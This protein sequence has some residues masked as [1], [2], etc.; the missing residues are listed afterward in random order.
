MS[1][2]LLGKVATADTWGASILLGDRL[3]LYKAMA[4]GA[5]ITPPSVPR[6]TGLHERYVREWLSGQVASGFLDCH[7]PERLLSSFHPSQV[8]AFGLS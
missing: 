8:C 6:K 4:D 3:G 7:P 1:C 5:V 2:G